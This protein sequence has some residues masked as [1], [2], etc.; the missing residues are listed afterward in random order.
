M[1]AP[2]KWAGTV[3][4]AS[5]GKKWKRSDEGMCGLHSKRTKVGR[6]GRSGSIIDDKDNIEGDENVRHGL[7]S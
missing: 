7:Q 2:L 6:K 5:A 4:D 1:C 3:S